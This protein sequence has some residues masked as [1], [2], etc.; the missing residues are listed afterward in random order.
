MKPDKKEPQLN[1]GGQVTFTGLHHLE[2]RSPRSNNAAQAGVAMTWAPAS[3]HAVYLYDKQ[4]YLDTDFSP[5]ATQAYANFVYGASTLDPSEEESVKPPPVAIPLLT[6]GRM[7]SGE[8]NSSFPLDL[9]SAGASALPEKIKIELATLFRR[10]LGSKY[11][12]RSSELLTAVTSTVQDAAQEHGPSGMSSLPI[13]SG[14]DDEDTEEEAL[15]QDQV[16]DHERDQLRAAIC[17]HPLLSEMVFAHIR[18]LKVW[19]FTV[20]S[21]LVG[22]LATVVVRNRC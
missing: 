5:N 12:S 10:E 8:Y 4:P 21:P 9:V 19:P 16:C 17:N 15:E 6:A 18:I 20:R 2:D 13:S 14:D 22:F 3:S 1:G 11:C 7:P